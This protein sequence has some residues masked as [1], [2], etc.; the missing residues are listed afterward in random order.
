MSDS[1][2]DHRGRLPSGK[3]CPESVG[4]GCA[5]C[6]TGDQKLPLRRKGRRQA[7]I[8]IRREMP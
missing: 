4:G 8:Q 1:D 2:R 6:C 3:R 7:K 5:Y